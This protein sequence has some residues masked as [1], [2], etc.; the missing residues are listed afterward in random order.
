[1]SDLEPIGDKAPKSEVA[2]IPRDPKAGEWCAPFTIP[3]GRP[4][5]YHP[6]C[7]DEVIK[8][9]ALGYSLCQMAA[10]FHVTR[11]TLQNWAEANPDFFA[12]LSQA[13]EYSQAW[14]EQWGRVG[15]TTAGFNAAHWKT[16]MYSRFRG[17]WGE[18]SE[19]RIVGIE[20][21]NAADVNRIDL[22]VLD[23]DEKETLKQLLLTAIG[24]YD[25][26]A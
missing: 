26:N 15:L 7:C 22:A 4:T 11:K 8:L 3:I 13:M 17:D 19:T 14:W 10:H 1:M 20:S 9:G 24:E 5:S 21:G 6:G 23:D 12:A 25:E 18:S 16:N 2:K